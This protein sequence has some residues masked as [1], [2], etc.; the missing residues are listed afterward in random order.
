MRLQRRRLT[1]L[2]QRWTTVGCPYCQDHPTHV[3]LFNDDPEPPADCTACGR[4]VVQ[5]V[6]RYILIAGDHDD[7]EDGGNTTGDARTTDSDR[8]S[9]L[10]PLV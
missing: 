8:V 10:S 2:E 1:A 4:H 3:Y 6:R 7:A 9:H 5:M